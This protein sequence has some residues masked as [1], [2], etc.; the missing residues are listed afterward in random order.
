MYSYDLDQARQ[1]LQTV[2]WDP[3]TRVPLLV[4]S[5]FP[6]TIAMAEIYQAD[7]QQIGINAAMEI[8]SGAET[9]NLLRKKLVGGAMFSPMGSMNLSP[10]T[11]SAFRRQ[12]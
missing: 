1:L 8:K 5:E 9:L 12:I 3:Q 7:L 6:A 10:A 11:S 2:G 4:A